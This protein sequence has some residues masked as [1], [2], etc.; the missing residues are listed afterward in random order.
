MGAFKNHYKVTHIY[1]YSQLQNVLFYKYINQ[2]ERCT[3]EY[4]RAKVNYTLS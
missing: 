2:S 3:T 4:K 1:T